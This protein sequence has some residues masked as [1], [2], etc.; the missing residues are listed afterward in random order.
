MEERKPYKSKRL[1]IAKQDIIAYFEKLEKKVLKKSD[2]SEIFFENKNYWRASQNTTAN[3]FISFLLN[4]TK[5][6]LQIFDFPSRRETRFTWG[7][8]SFYQ[9]VFSLNPNAYFSHYTAL[10]VHGLT[11]Q[12]PKTYYLNVELKPINIKNKGLSQQSIDFAFRNKPRISN[13]V[14]ILEDKKICMLNSKFTNSLGIIELKHNSEGVMKVT[15]VERTLID[16]VV[17]PVYSGGIFEVLKAYK[18]AKEKVSINK[19]VSYLKKLD[20]TYPYYQAIGF[21]IEKAEIYNKSQINLLKK[22]NIEYNFYLTQQMKEVNYSK[23]WKLF[24]PKNF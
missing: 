14:A 1:T 21:F 6:K 17:R 5:L 12:I 20:Y 24:Y 10:S 3:N 11:E 13:N 8:V 22:F 9:L 19:L 23:E 2:I 18:N 4:E 7:E 15:D 16:I